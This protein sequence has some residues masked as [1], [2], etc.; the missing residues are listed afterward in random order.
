MNVFL[1]LSGRDFVGRQKK[2]EKLKKHLTRAGALAL[3]VSAVYFY[4]ESL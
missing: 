4:L 1:V 3:F 2:Q